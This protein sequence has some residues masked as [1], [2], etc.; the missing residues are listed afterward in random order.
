MSWFLLMALSCPKT[1]MDNQTN[2]KWTA[3]DYK[4]LEYAK[5][6]C[7]EIYPDSKCVKYFKKWGKQDYSVICGAEVEE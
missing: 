5:K 1:L 6:R 4:T 3:H 2:F 7:V